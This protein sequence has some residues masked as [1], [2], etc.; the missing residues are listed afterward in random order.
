MIRS[1]KDK[2]TEALF[3][4][5]DVAAFR[6]FRE[7]AERR[8]QILDSAPSLRTLGALRSNGLHALTRDRQRQHAI[9]INKQW[10]ICSIWGVNGPYDVEICDYH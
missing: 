2:R 3:G 1:F 9:R 7:Q 6:S 5:A 8:L 10:R 4:G